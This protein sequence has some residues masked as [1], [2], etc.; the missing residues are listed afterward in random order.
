MPRITIADD[1]SNISTS[2]VLGRNTGIP[3]GSG[4]SLA[5]RAGSDGIGRVDLVLESAFYFK[6]L[7]LFGL[8]VVEGETLFGVLLP[9]RF[10]YRA[11]ERLQ[12]QGIPL[13]L[14]CHRSWAT[15][16]FPSLLNFS[17]ARCASKTASTA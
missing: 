10:R 5:L 14:E 17:A 13:S 7:E 8:E 1:F 4:D 11:H 6:N 3:T 12:C 16:Y 2:T 15:D 9:L